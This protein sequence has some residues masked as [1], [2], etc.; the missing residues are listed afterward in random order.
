M[1]LFQTQVAP[2]EVRPQGKICRFAAALFVAAQTPNFT[3]AGSPAPRLDHVAR[4]TL[5][6]RV[7]DADSARGVPC[8]ITVVDE[9]KSLVPLTVPPRSNLAAR[10][11]VVYTP[12]GQAEIEVASGKYT[13]YAA[14]GFEYGV[15]H[16]TVIVAG[17]ESAAV[18]LKIRREVPT[19]GLIACDTHVHTL[20]HSG[21]GDATV[22]E[23]AVTLA[24]EGIELP[25][26]TDHDHLTDDLASAA[27]LMGVRSYFTP[28]VGAEVT[29]RVGHFNAFPL[30]TDRPAPDNKSTDW[31][32]ILRGIRSSPGER[33]VVLNHPRDLHGNFR[34]FAQEHFN[35]V[36]GEHKRSMNGIDALEVINSGAMQSD[37]ML[38]VRD[39]MALLSRGARLTAVGS[40]DS[41]DVARHIVGQGRTY[42][43]AQDDDPA[44]IDVESAARNLRAGRALVSLGLL[45]RIT[46][47]DRYEPGDLATGSGEKLKVKVLV[48]GPSWTGVNRVE[49]F[50]NGIAIDDQRFTAETRPGLKF[51]Y[52][53]EIAR[54]RHDIFLVAVVTG[55]GVTAPYWAIE[56]PYQ[57]TSQTYQPRVMAITNS[58]YI[59]GDNDG[60][61]TSPLAY[62]SAI[63]QRSGSDTAALIGTLSTYDETI[64]AQAAGL[65]RMAGKGVRQAELSAQLGKAPEA[66]R[67]GFARFTATQAGAP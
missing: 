5:T 67:R 9:H 32:E 45:A 21:H 61:W 17:G 36:T 53:K 44:H 26:A 19:E 38:P 11:G 50:A 8:R 27:E 41:H 65:C 7:T 16:A 30:P 43:T 33:I 34:P 57:P 66:V 62:A 31:A 15:D 46:V 4:S 58:I 10:T 28:V 40:S 18:G 59:D 24:G 56:Q 52:A 20:T 42:I 39:W 29:T 49:L 47:D 6:I 60:S 54:P 2:A 51:S 23:R 37:P 35:A 12:D 14:R 13:V 25:I 48:L 55:P 63:V 1:I 3:Q 64:A 22:V